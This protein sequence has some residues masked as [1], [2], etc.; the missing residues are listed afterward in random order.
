MIE[1]KDYSVS[2][3]ASDDRNIRNPRI[4]ARNRNLLIIIG[5]AVLVSVIA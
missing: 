5:M 2:E 1:E 4:F 3:P